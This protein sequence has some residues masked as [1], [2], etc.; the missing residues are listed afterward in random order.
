M[1]NNYPGKFIVIYGVNNIGKT[2][3]A[4]M[5]VDKLKAGGLKA[6]YLKYP[7]YDLAL[8]GIILDNYL[9]QGNTFN[10][11]P[12]EA[13]IIFAFNRAQYQAAL[14]EKLS[15]GIN[16]VAEDYAGTGIA[17]GLGA[18]VDKKFLKFINSYLL[19]EDLAFLL[20][21][22]RFMAAAEN[23]H[24]HENDN[25]LTGKVR[26]VHLKLGREFGW[27]KINA[28]Q[29]IEKIHEQIWRIIFKKLKMK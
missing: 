23:R 21:G 11:T 1:P 24:R 27:I 2:T 6:E 7:V 28:N 22:E 19:K 5:L 12:R 18:G 8:S 26:A 4:K 10:L 20:D 13:Q 9:R 17:W 14:K 25:E 16:I 3:Q 15:S 29:P